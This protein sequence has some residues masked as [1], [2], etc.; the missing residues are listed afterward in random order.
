MS[1]K[2]FGNDF[3]DLF[4]HL[5]SIFTITNEMKKLRSGFLLKEMLDRFSK[6]LEM[7]LNPDRTLW[8]YFAHG[9][10]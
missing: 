6:K 9:N 1:G 2:K 7:T 4:K 8:L 10:I 3:H 5:Y